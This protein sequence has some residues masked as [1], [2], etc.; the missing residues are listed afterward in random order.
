MIHYPKISVII[1]V[2]NAEL[3]FEKCL[4]SL[5]EQTFGGIEFVFINDNTPDNSF[6]ILENV[7]ADYP[8]RKKQIK[9]INNKY[10]I[11]SGASRNIGLT[12]ADGE[13]IVFC[14]S[15]DWCDL[16]LYQ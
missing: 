1:P 3:Y 4:R 9:I 13:Y 11:G 6:N 10:N 5:F 15:D 16:D 14:D 8:D 7:L 2:Y 12:V